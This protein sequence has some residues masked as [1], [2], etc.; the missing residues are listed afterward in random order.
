[1]ISDR[2]F[3]PHIHRCEMVVDPGAKNIH[4]AEGVLR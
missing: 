2:E 4:G 1:V 3:F